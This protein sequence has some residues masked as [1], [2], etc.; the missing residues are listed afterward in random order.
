MKNNMPTTGRDYPRLYE[1]CRNASDNRGEYRGFTATQ[2]RLQ[3]EVNPGFGNLPKIGVAL[4]WYERRSMT[5]T[6]TTSTTGDQGGMTVSQEV[7]EIGQAFRDALVLEKLGAR[8][9]GGLTGNV[10]FP[11]SKPGLTAEW[12]S[13]T[14]TAA[15]SDEKLAQMDLAPKRVTAFIDVSD[16]LLIQGEAIEPFLRAELLAALAVEIQQKAINGSGA[17]SQ[18]LGLLN[19]PGIATVVG[20]PSGAAPTYTNVSDLEYA[21]TGIGKADRGHLGWLASPLGR[22]KLRQTPMFANG[23]QPI[24]SEREAAALLGH[25]AGVTPSVPDALS[26]GTAV[27][28][29]SAL[30]FGEFSEL[31]LALWGPGVRVYAI[32][33]TANFV[34]G[35]RRLFATAYVDSGIRTPTAFAAMTDAL[36]N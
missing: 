23:S 5:A 20:G 28:S 33:D 17:N 12:L 8:V 14:A 10:N 7:P 4:P 30:V 25:L 1:I 21:V 18:P 24:W 15:G 6:G 27:A 36:C 29:C 34:T 22:K 19:T 9:F 11:R 26:K 16:L 3:E 35:K 31:F 32:R 13:E 2:Q